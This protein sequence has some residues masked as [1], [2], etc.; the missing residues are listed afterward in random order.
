AD[1]EKLLEVIRE[2]L[3]AVRN[4]Y[5]DAR[6]TE[7]LASKEDFSV[8]DLIAEEQVVV[9][10]SHGG[11]AKMQPLDTYRA[12]RRGGRG[13]AATAVKDEDYVDHLLVAGTHD[14]LLCFT[15]AGKVF[16]LRVFEL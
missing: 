12:Q 4:D 2:E 16:W 5:G 15:S 13:K 7:I 11:Y 6:R 3:R 1:Q 14:T 8:E 10:F 9:T